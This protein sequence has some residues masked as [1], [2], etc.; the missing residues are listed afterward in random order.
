MPTVAVVD[1][2]KIKFYPSDHPPPHFHTEFGEHR[3]SIHIQTLRLL[4]G[5]LPESKRRSV[6]NGRPKERTC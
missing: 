5:T 4:R 1:G 3:A 2:V 6:L